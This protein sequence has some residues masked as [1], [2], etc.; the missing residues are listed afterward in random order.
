MVIGSDPYIGFHNK[1][2]GNCS[3]STKGS[4]T[5]LSYSAW[6]HCGV[7]QPVFRNTYFKFTS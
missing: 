2:A 4:R 7:S 3:C 6:Q 1:G 5:S